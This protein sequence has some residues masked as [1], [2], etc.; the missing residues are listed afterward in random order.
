MDNIHVHGL[1]PSDGPLAVPW[2]TLSSLDH[3]LSLPGGQGVPSCLSGVWPV[4]SLPLCHLTHPCLGLLCP[5]IEDLDR[6]SI[7]VS[8][9]L[10]LS[11]EI[12]S[13]SPLA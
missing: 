10:S 4:A 8:P 2:A 9:K 1:E 11:A 3:G 5:G 7:A 6:L 13:C 12:L